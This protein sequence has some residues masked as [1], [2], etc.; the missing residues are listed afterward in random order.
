MKS[1]KEFITE[2]KGTPYKW[3]WKFF[4]SNFK[5][6]QAEAKA[7]YEDG[8]ITIVAEKKMNNHWQIVYWIIEDSYTTTSSGVPISF[9]PEDIT[10]IF[11]TIMDITNSLIKKIGDIESI[12][13]IPDKQKNIAKFKPIVQSYLPSGWKFSI[14]HEKIYIRKK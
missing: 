9:S 13:I 1:F 5:K 14:I 3:R 12:E 2:A 4:S 8:E 11:A 6:G 10:K 7:R